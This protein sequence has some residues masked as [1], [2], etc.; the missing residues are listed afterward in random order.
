MLLGSS[1]WRLKVPHGLSHAASRP[2]SDT[3]QS[4]MVFEI[5]PNPLD[6]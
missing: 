2:N 4:H 5:L 3:V 6:T 1:E